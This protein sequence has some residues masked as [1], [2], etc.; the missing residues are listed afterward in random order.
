MDL[1]ENANNREQ[2]ER[3]VLMANVRAFC[4]S[5][6]GRDVMW[7]IL[8]Y[9]SIYSSIPGKFESGK[10][11]VGLNIIDLLNEAEP[12]LYAKLLLEKEL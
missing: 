7:E 4:K 10:R 9:C 8:S 3:A 12:K 2:K 11:N 6:A 1:Q 5:T